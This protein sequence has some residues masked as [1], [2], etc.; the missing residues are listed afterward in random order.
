MAIPIEAYTGDGLVTGVVQTP[1]RL[2]DALETLDEVPIAPLHGLTLDG[3]R[4]EASHA[5]LAPDAL[6]LV[7]PDEAEVAVHAS[8]HPVT[9]AIGPYQVT[10]ELPTLPGFDPGRALARPSGS[11]I[12]LREATVRAREDPERVLALHARL[13]VNRYDVE[14]V[15]AA[16]MLGF[17]F[18]GARLEVVDPAAVEGLAPPAADPA[19]VA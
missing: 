10:G 14:E 16:L 11:F 12:L 4:T 2:R 19:P 18:P 7:V 15:S 6:L 1:G 5:T 9:L 8:W 13:L 3:R 17:F